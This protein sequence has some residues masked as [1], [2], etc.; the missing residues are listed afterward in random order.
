[1][2]VT[3]WRDNRQKS[4][5]V[6][7]DTDHI[8]PRVLLVALFCS[9]CCD[10]ILLVA[11][12]AASAHTSFTPLVWRLSTWAQSKFTMVRS[13]PFVRWSKVSQQQA[14]V[15][16]CCAIC[17]CAIAGY[18]ASQLFGAGVSYTYDDVIM[19]P[20]HI[21]FGAHEVCISGGCCCRCCAHSSSSSKGGSPGIRER[22]A[23]CKC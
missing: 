15:T 17:C 13:A 2:G 19:H 10:C 4:C 5:T 20:G 11:T 14:L 23:P 16:P 9:L 6:K 21:C 22:T 8:H 18:T 3:C 12:Q 1:M 7:S